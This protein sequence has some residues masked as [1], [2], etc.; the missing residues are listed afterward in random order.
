MELDSRLFQ[1]SSSDKT[2]T[3]LG[4]CKVIDVSFHCNELEWKLHSVTFRN[5]YSYSVSLFYKSS[6]A[7]EW[8]TCLKEEKLMSHSGSE[9]NSQD[10]VVLTREH[11]C[12]ADKPSHLRIVLKQPCE[13]W[14]DFGICDLKYIGISSTSSKTSGKQVDRGL[15][16]QPLD[17][18]QRTLTTLDYTEHYNIPYL[19]LTS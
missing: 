4:R 15:Q 6:L 18:I 10:V 2:E 16:Q 1:L 3:T 19:S 9:R 7:Y 5:F 14:K 12:L 11:S 8:T 13:N 17:A